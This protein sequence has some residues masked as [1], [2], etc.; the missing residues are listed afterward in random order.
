MYN[1]VAMPSFLKVKTVEIPVFASISNNILQ[2]TGGIGGILGATKLGSKAFKIKVM[3][4]PNLLTDTNAS[5]ARDLAV[6]LMGDSWKLTELYFSD[7]PFIKYDA[8][9]NNSMSIT[10]LIY[11]G[12]GDI[13]FI[14][15]SGV[16]RGTIYGK[17]ATVNLGARTASLVYNGTA[18]SYALITYVPS[19]AIVE[20]NNWTFTNVTT[21]ERI[22]IKNFSSGSTNILDS[23]KRKVTSTGTTTIKDIVLSQ[24]EWI[25]FPKQGTYSLSWNYGTTS[26][27]EIKCTEYYL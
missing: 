13:E 4:V 26:S 25:K 7:D 11:A 18:P 6:W 9:V 21:G 16:G 14:V 3:I 22:K 24:T 19:Q 12:E 2:K 1:N 20:G 5:M 27:M 10:D 15:P 23:A 17:L 8:I